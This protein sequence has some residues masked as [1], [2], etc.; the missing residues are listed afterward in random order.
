MV[1]FGGIIL[2][3]SV[4]FLFVE[5]KKNHGYTA[6]LRLKWKLGA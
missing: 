2:T 3:F 1:F 5:I 6:I 4:F